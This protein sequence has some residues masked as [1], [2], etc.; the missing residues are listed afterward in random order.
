M[1]LFMIQ[2]KGFRIIDFGISILTEKIRNK[3]WLFMSVSLKFKL[4]FCI[5]T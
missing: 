4:F 1:F 5:Y 3:T 2:V